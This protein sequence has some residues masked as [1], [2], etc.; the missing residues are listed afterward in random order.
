[1]GAD[2]GKSK[3]GRVR[4]WTIVFVANTCHGHKPNAVPR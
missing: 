2:A 3:A 4:M 1:M